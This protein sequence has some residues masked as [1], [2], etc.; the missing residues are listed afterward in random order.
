[1]TSRVLES[2][3]SIVAGRQEVITRPLLRTVEGKPAK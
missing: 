1:M 2:E 3:S